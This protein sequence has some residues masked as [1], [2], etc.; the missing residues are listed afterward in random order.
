MEKYRLI[1]DPGHAWLEVPLSEIK[2]LDIQDKIST[3]SYKHKGFGYLE[4]DCDMGVF[5]NEKR[6]LGET[7]E[8]IEVF[9]ENTRIRAYPMFS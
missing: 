1:N 8:F 9:Q 5:M 4:E 2:R 7:V 6:R 3:Y